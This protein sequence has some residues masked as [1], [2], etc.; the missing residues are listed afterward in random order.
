MPV[1]FPATIV[2][3]LVE[4]QSAHTAHYENTGLFPLDAGRGSASSGSEGSWRSF[5]PG[6]RWREPASV[7]TARGFAGGCRP[8]DVWATRREVV[9][10]GNASTRR[11][12]S[13]AP[14]ARTSIDPPVNAVHVERVRGLTQGGRYSRCFQLLPL[15]S[16]RSCSFVL[17]TC[18]RVKLY[19]QFANIKKEIGLDYY[20]I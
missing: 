20:K 7:R 19:A 4:L 8:L 2:F 9:L 13:A 17:S 5:R 1:V 11:A 18:W 16:A 10:I 12:W 14:S 15:P 3:C 6:R